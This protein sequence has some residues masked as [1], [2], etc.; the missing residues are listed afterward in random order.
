M[1]TDKE[2]VK[3]QNT[4]REG[5]SL[6]L[7]YTY[8]VGPRASNKKV[9]GESRGAKGQTAYAVIRRRRHLYIL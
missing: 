4:R 9:S 8:I 1:T 5:E 2:S 7:S 3:L 6:G